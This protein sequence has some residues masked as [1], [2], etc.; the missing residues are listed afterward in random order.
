MVNSHFG[1]VLQAIR[2]NDFRAEA[3]GY[4]TVV[5]RT[6]ANCVAALVATLAGALMALWLRYV[7]PKTVLGFEIMTDILLIVVIGGMGRMYGA[8][9]GSVLFIVAQN[10]LQAAMGRAAEALVGPAVARAARCI[11]TAG[12]CGWDSSSSPACTTFPRG[13]WAGSAPATRRTAVRGD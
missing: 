9:I 13:S 10:Y 4:R 12:C 3:L 11:R 8:V 2:E 5:Y 6:L 7:G 1:R